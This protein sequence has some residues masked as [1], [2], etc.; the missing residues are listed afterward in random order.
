[1]VEI[2]KELPTSDL[3]KLQKSMRTAW[4]RL[5]GRDSAHVTVGRIGAVLNATLKY[6]G[7]LPH[8]GSEPRGRESLLTRAVRL[9]GDGQQAACDFFEQEFRHFQEIAAAAT[10]SGAVDFVAERRL[11]DIR[12][13]MSF[14]AKRIAR[15]LV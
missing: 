13:T 11:S 2:N 9:D 7:A 6:E 1:M 14:L 12:A 15:Q 4:N 8:E 5:A 3:F 10:A